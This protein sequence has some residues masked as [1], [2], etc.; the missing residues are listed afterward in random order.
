[1]QQHPEQPS[2]RIVRRREAATRLGVSRSTLYAYGDPKSPSYKAD[3]PKPLRLGGIVGF[4]DHELDAYVG[5]LMKAR[6]G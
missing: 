2:F 4:I 3:L 1:M 5:R 6:Q